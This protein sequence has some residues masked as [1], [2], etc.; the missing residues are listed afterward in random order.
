[1]QHQMED[2]IRA[3]RAADV[4]V[5]PAEAIDAHEAV[6]RICLLYTSPSPRDS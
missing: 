3:L 2:F 4:G 6:A 5:S 1:M